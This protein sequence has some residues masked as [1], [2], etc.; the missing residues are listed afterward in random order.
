MDTYLLLA[1]GLAL[2]ILGGELLVRG[3]AR[4]AALLGMSPLLIGLTLVGF[5]TSAPELV[6]SVEASFMG[7]PG[8]AIG[9]IVGSNIANVLL[10]LGIAA[11]LSPIAVGRRALARDGTIGLASAVAFI[12]IA[13]LMPLDRLIGAVLVTGLALYLYFAYRQEMTGAPSAHTAAYDKREAHDEVLPGAIQAT[14]HSSSVWPPFMLAIAG[15]I[16]VIVGGKL[17]VKG[18]VALASSAGI[19][20]TILGLTVVAIGTSLPELVTSVIA[21]LRRHGDI[22][23]GNILG[24]NIY[25]ILGIGGVTALIAPTDVPPE[26][27][28]FDGLVMVAVSILLLVVAR[29]GHHISRVEGSVLLSGYGLYVYSIWPA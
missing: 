8:I 20:E 4:T 15:L 2:L 21:A 19:S 3:A 22:A 14:P 11:V 13:Y 27:V 28:R 6:T 5:G 25:N 29:T 1:G 7:A 16:I 26:I 24:S 17:L 23:L 18:A 12:A 10:I 9:N